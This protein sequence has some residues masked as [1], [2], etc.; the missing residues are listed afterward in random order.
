[1]ADVKSHVA[2]SELIGSIYDC[3]VDPGGWER[4]LRA[5]VDAFD[6]MTAILSLSDLRQNRILIYRQVGIEPHFEELLQKHQQEV[7]AGLGRNLASWMS[8]DVPYLLSRHTTKEQRDASPYY[9]ECVKAGGVIDTMQ[10]FLVH[11]RERFSG[12]AVTR[13]ESRS[14]FSDADIELGSLL[15]P[16]LRRAVAISNILDAQTIERERLRQTL[17]A[18]RCGVILVDEQ[19]GI[20]HANRPGEQLLENGDILQSLRGKL[21]ACHEPAAR[22]L[23]AAIRTA[24]IPGLPMGTTGMA[25]LLSEARE[26]P[27]FAH[28]LPMRHGNS[29]ANHIPDTVAAV[30]VSASPDE[31]SVVEV[32]ATAYGLTFAEQRV[33]TGILSGSTL[34]ETASTLGVAHT[35]AKTHLE[36]IFSKTGVNRQ[37]DLIRLSTRAQPPA[38]I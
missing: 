29:D 6:G 26:R 38:A 15:L 5:L 37:A 13:H 10:Y 14:E 1:M 22:E 12:F 19:G 28:V 31:R 20:L 23:R 25:I 18:V 35:T 27:S 32:I 24:A 17:D 11:T 8:L 16:H 9:R 7:N 3:A 34:A 36:A 30:F 33:L 21:H 2:L 4:T